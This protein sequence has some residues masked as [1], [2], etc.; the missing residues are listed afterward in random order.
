[1][2]ILLARGMLA[3]IVSGLLVL[4]L[5]RWIGEPQVDLAMTFETSMDHAKGLAPEPDVVSR[6]TQ[7]SIGLLTAIAVYGT[8]IGGIFGLVFA[9]AYGRVHITSPRAL[10]A[11]M[12]VLGFVAVVLVPT[13]KYPANPPSVGNPETI[14][15]RTAA[16]FLMILFS[17][18]AMILS[19]Q[20]ERRL[21]SRIGAWNASI[22]AAV[23]FIVIVGLISR[24]LPEFNEVP[25]DFPATLMWRFRVAALGM[26]ALMWAT[27]GLIFGW[28]TERDLARRQIRD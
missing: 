16:F 2:G 10:S 6:Q 1:M 9:F 19:I 3:G 12:A 26:Q 17:L 5:A 11:A 24:F 23:L 21:R 14:G 25:A 28:L 15:A 20:T 18:A 7:K 22:V 8:A 4:A 27:I 13:L